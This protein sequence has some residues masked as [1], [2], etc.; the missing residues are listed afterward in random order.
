M[1]VSGAPQVFPFFSPH[2]NSG[3]SASLR[4]VDH[5]FCPG[6]RR[7]KNRCNS[8][9]STGSPA[10]SPS[11]VTPMAGAWDWPKIETVRFPVYRCSYCIL[12]QRSK[13]LPECGI[14]LRDAFASQYRDRALAAAGGHGG[15]HRDA[16]VAAGVRRAAGKACAARMTS[17]SG[18]SRTLPPS[19]EINAAV[20][21]RRSD[22]FSRSRAAFI[23]PCFALA[24]RG[25]ARNDRDQIGNRPGIQRNSVQ[26]S[27]AA[28]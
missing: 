20:V 21:C 26:R 11:T 13:I 8:S 5:A 23:N 6:A 4:G 19:A 14:G 3:A 25:E 22:S 10:G 12:P 2:K 27:R 15:A 18:S 17:P 1:A 24:E 16:V 7:L 28:R 9:G